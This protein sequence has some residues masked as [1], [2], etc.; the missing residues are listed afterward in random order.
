[1]DAVPQCDVSD[2]N[3][4]AKSSVH[5]PRADDSNPLRISSSSF[6]FGEASDEEGDE[7]VSSRCIG[8]SEEAQCVL[9]S[10]GPMESSAATTGQLATSVMEMSSMEVGAAGHSDSRASTS[11]SEFITDEGKA[12]SEALLEAQRALDLARQ[13]V[14]SPA[15]DQPLVACHAKSMPSHHTSQDRTSEMLIVDRPPRSAS[16]PSS[17][18]SS[19][20]SSRAAAVRHRS[21]GLEKIPDRQQRKE[22]DCDQAARCVHV[23]REAALRAASQK[24]AQ[25]EAN[26]QEEEQKAVVK[27]E[28]EAR[29]QFSRRYVKTAARRAKS[30][31]QRQREIVQKVLVD[32][33]DMQ[34]KRIDANDE[35][36]RNLQR[37]CGESDWSD[38]KP[39]VYAKSTPR[40][41]PVPPGTDAKAIVQ[42]AASLPEIVQRRRSASYGARPIKGS[43]DQDI[44]LLPPLAPVL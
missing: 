1:M 43:K 33:D 17:A 15:L 5:P 44:T 36:G 39:V 13:Y 24:R 37:R 23:R 20:L 12:L 41:V 32:L 16:Q 42:Q 29:D 21:C 35:K 31:Q 18:R 7:H 30:E 10:H 9:G 25:Q 4:A 22:R 28:R 14:T 11:F 2:S 26:Q 19:K 3:L 34:R 27:A 38:S 6:F 8:Q 40:M